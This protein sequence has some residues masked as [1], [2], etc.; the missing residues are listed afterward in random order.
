MCKLIEFNQLRGPKHPLPK[1][2]L[3]FANTRELKRADAA[4]E[5]KVMKRARRL[6][7]INA[8]IVD[9]RS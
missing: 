2:Y 6:E 1:S 3:Q 4:L 9:C 8:S 5:R 7:R